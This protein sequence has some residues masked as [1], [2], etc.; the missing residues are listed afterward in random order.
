MKPTPTKLMMNAQEPPTRLAERS[1]PGEDIDP[2]ASVIGAAYRC[3]DCDRV[4]LL[5]LELRHAMDDV[6]CKSIF[7]ILRNWAIRRHEL[8]LG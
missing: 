2:N 4:Q 7:D 6:G 3:R 8:C 1:R 5:G